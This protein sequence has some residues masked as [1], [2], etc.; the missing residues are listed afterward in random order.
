MCIRDRCTY[1]ARRFVGICVIERVRD[2]GW[3]NDGRRLR[4]GARRL[5]AAIASDIQRRSQSQASPGGMHWGHV[6]CGP[7][8]SASVYGDA[9]L[10]SPAP[11]VIRRGYLRHRRGARRPALP[12]RGAR[13]RCDQRSLWSTFQARRICGSRRCRPDRV[14]DASEVTRPSCMFTTCVRSVTSHRP[15]A[16]TCRSSR[17]AFGTARR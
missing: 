2:H 1:D 5:T 13:S 3:T 14:V 17:G 10:S 8:V 11:S 12:L 4:A 7:F 15:S 9:R 16:C 6:T